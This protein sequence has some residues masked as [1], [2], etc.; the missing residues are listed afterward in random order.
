MVLEC[1]NYGQEDAEVP[2]VLRM[3]DAAAMGLHA[4]VLLAATPGRRLSSREIASALEVSE[5]HLSKVLRRLVRARLAR[6]AR[7][8]RGGFSLPPRGD[9]VTLL[10]VYEAVEGPLMPDDCLLGT[11]ICGGKNCIFGGLLAKLNEE[12]WQCFSDTRLLQL[13]RVFR[14]EKS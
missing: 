4:M 8:P 3:S 9:R 10:E 6:S 1:D 11:Q 5:A 2:S 7:G 13:T 14:G 12:V